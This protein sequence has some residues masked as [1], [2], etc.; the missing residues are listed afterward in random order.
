MMVNWSATNTVEF[1]Y[2]PLSSSIIDDVE[3]KRIINET[4]I[5]I[6]K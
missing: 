5:T 3:I 2:I 4:S 1:D 6:N